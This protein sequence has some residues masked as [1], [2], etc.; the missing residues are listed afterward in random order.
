MEDHLWQAGSHCPIWS[1]DCLVQAAHWCALGASCLVN[2]LLGDLATQYFA[3]RDVFCAGRVAQEV[4]TEG[5]GTVQENKT[6]LLFSSLLFSSLFS[7]LFSSLLFSS[8]LFSS[9][10]FS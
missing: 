9:L 5:S 8:L 6:L 1:P 2:C 4:G 10:L 3:D 7:P